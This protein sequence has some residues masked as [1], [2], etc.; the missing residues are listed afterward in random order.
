MMRMGNYPMNASERI[1]KHIDDLADWRGKVLEQLRKLIRD[2]APGAIEE[3]KW[4]TPVW[5][6]TGEPLND[7]RRSATAVNTI[8]HD[9][10]HPSQI[11][12][13]IVPAV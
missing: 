6:N 7:N 5:S 3:W 4:N 12:L 13:P 8:Y 1:T 10:R 11:V 2:A 9:D